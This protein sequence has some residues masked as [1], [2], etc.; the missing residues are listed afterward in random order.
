MTGTTIAV[1]AGALVLALVIAWDVIQSQRI[2]RLEK[3]V[4]ALEKK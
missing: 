1:L 3:R 4:A 2:D